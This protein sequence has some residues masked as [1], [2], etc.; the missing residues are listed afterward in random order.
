MKREL[1]VQ[2]TA[3]ARIHCGLIS[4][5]NSLPINFGG[6]GLMV[7][8]PPTIVSLA[9]GAGRFAGESHLHDLVAA[10]IR[11]CQPL[12]E[13]GCAEV[14]VN[15]VTSPPRHSGFGSGTQLSFAIARALLELAEVEPLAPREM[16]GMLQRGERSTIGTY[17]FFR[18]GFLVDRGK[19]VGEDFSPLDFRTDFPDWPIVIIEFPGLRGLHGLAEIQAFERIVQTTAQQRST[20]EHLLRER[21]LPAITRADFDAF[22]ESI[23]EYGMRSGEYYRDFQGGSFH[24]EGV[25]RVVAWLRASGLRGVVQSSWGP[26]L[27]A[28]AR[29][30]EAAMELQQRL[31]QTFGDSIQ[32]IITTANNQGARVQLQERIIHA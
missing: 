27:V 8:H 20:M 17:G 12:T 18:G 4:V 26:T 5:G 25:A 2:I 31:E 24:S 30:R 6:C 19:A 13:I 9:W 21:I 23:Y 22:S 7:H 3:P 10:L 32:P 11:R 1:S 28:F 16:S 29:C 14:D 15:I